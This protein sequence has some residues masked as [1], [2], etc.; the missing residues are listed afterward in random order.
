MPRWNLRNLAIPIGLMVAFYLALYLVGSSLYLFSFF[1]DIAFVHSFPLKH[2]L[3]WFTVGISLALLSSLTVWPFSLAIATLLEHNKSRTLA[4]YFLKLI[5]YLASLP[6]VLFVFAYLTIFGSRGFL[7]IKKF[8]FF[9]FASENFFTQA[10]AFALTLLLYPLSLLQGA[11]SQPTIDSFY[12]R[13]LSGVIEFAE[14]GLVATVVA[15]GLF[16][17]LLPKMVLH[18]RKILQQDE[19]LR[20]F[21]IIKSLG[22]TPWESVHLTVMQ[23]MKT[24]FNDIILVF[25][26]KSF[27]EGLITF[28]L[29]NAFFAKSSDL[30]WSSSLSSIYVR[31]SLLGEG[32]LNKLLALSGFLL[33][34]Y[35]LLT[36]VAALQKNIGR[37]KHV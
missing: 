20:S 27:F 12:H 29:L 9:L 19:Q 34:S 37:E 32:N 11:S 13:M 2:L 1:Q 33:L 25:T 23:S 5:S 16:L 14:V 30:H 31:E 36:W 6:L 3:G 24:K 22:G 7:L 4:N 21:E 28:S 8:W 17:Y 35:L 15:L 26:Q 10:I 18:M